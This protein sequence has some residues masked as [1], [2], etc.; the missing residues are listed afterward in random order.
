M[1]FEVIAKCFPG[2]LRN[3][4]I[5]VFDT[6]DLSSKHEPYKPF[7]ISFNQETLTIPQRIYCDKKQLKKLLKLSQIQQLIG[8]CFF[9]RHH[10]GYV[11][12]RCIRQV[13][14]S[15]EEFVAPFIIQLLGEYIVEI[16]E[17]IYDNR[18]SLG[19][20]GIMKLLK[21]NPDYYQRTHQRVYSYWN[22]YYRRYYPKYKKKVKP[23]DKSIYDYPGIKMLK[24][25]NS[26]IMQK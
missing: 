3:D 21:D 6:L 5:K 14:N 18:E 22:C 16:I 7:D 4:V 12:E 9:S 15:K 13:L 8:F 19:K 20:L 25:I 17:L 10:N 23:T 1:E 24:F 2:Y 26:E 11:R